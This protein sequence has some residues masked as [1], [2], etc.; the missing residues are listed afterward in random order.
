MAGLM[1]RDMVLSTKHIASAEGFALVH[2]QVGRLWHH[3]GSVALYAHQA[4]INYCLLQ[5]IMLCLTVH[6]LTEQIFICLSSCSIFCFNVSIC[7]PIASYSIA[8]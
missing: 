5:M 2:A 4:M 6:D 3:L 8:A 7:S 1:I